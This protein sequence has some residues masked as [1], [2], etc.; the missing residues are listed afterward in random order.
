MAT[1]RLTLAYDG[2]DFVGWQ[3]Q[4]GKRTI[5]EELEATLGRITGERPKCIASGRT[6]AG[7]HALGQVVSFSSETRHEPEVLTRAL[8]AELPDDMLVFE[9]TRAPDGFHAQRDAVRKRYRYAIEDG[10]LCDLF[11]RR[12]LWHIYQRLNVEA[13]QAAAAPLVGTHDFTSYETTGSSRLTTV[14]TIFDLT[15]ERHT[16]DLTDRVIVEVEADGFLYNMVRNIVGTLVTM[17]KGKEPIDWPARVLELRD[18]TKA[19]MTAP[20]QG[21]FLVGVE[22]PKDGEFGVQS[23]ECGIE[24]TEDDF[25]E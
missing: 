23:A 18:R 21:L 12:Y 22:Y 1:F 6:D 7:V 13:M 9:V 2:T 4:P 14:R 8:N 16:N 25:V 10:R 3:W 15:V 20:A 19:G 5:Q 24:A 11:A 17:G